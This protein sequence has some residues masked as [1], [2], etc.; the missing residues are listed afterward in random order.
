MTG[1]RGVVLWSERPDAM[2]HMG[3]NPAFR[4]CQYLED[5]RMTWPAKKDLFERSA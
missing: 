1:N 4:G 3:G 2:A 5:L